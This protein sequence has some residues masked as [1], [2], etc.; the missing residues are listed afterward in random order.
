MLER[1][2]SIRLLTPMFSSGS[3]VSK[4]EFR[5][6]EL[7]AL[8]RATFREFFEYRTVADLKEAEGFLFGNTERKSPVMIL[9]GESKINSINGD[10]RNM[11]LHEEYE[12]YKKKALVEN[13]EIKIRFRSKYEEIL[14]LWMQILQLAAWTGGLGKRSRKG[15]GVFQICKILDTDKNKEIE[16]FK[17]EKLIE[18]LNKEIKFKIEK[19]ELCYRVRKKEKGLEKNQPQ[20]VSQY[21]FNCEK[22]DKGKW[23]YVKKITIIKIEDDN[24]SDAMTNVLANVS[25]LTRK[26]LFS[27][28]INLEKIKNSSNKNKINYKIRVIRNSAKAKENLLNNFEITVLGH[29]ITKV[30]V[31]KK[32][33]GYVYVDESTKKII[34]KDII[35]KVNPEKFNIP[36]KINLLKDKEILEEYYNEEYYNEEYYNKDILGNCGELLPRFASPV[37]IT[38]YE[39]KSEKY[40]LIK[41]LN[42]DYI[43]NENFKEQSGDK[44]YIQWYIDEIKDIALGRVK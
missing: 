41:E 42:Y 6:T 40:L 9:N 24:N 5:I 37:C 20:N 26:R 33:I 31:G 38:V 21:L 28:D 39:F 19:K 43:Y 25:F 3:D 15:M 13:V 34:K 36:E 17:F 2:V 12:K 10:F 1:Q 11:V 18:K 35:I 27:N 14:N 22:V 23:N 29:P 44:K 30:R 16:L 8:M 4:A 7:K 32:N